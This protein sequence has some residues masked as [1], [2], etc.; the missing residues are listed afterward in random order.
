MVLRRGSD[1]GGPSRTRTSSPGRRGGRGGPNAVRGV[2]KDTSKLSRR[3]TWLNDKGG[4]ITQIRFSEVKD[5][6][7]AVGEGPAMRVLKEVEEKRSEIRDPTAW[8]RTAARRTLDNGAIGSAPREHHESMGKGK[9]RAASPM[10]AIG[11]PAGHGS[12]EAERIRKR[13]V[14]LNH[15]ASLAKELDPN[16]CTDLLVKLDR[17]DAM[18]ILKNL[19]ENAAVVRDPIAY[20][21]TSARRT[22]EGD[23]PIDHRPPAAAGRRE[24]PPPPASSSISSGGIASKGF[25]LRMGKKPGFALRTVLKSRLKSKR[26]PKNTDS[27]AVQ[28]EKRVGWLNENIDLAQELVFDEVAD[29]LIAVGHREAM[30]VLKNLEENAPQVRNPTAYVANAAHRTLEDRPLKDGGPMEDRAASARRES[31]A[32]LAV[33]GARRISEKGI[34]SRIGKRQ[35]PPWVV[36]DKGISARIGLRPVIKKGLKE[37]RD[38]MQSDKLAE[39]LETRVSWLNDNAKLAHDLVFEK[40]ADTLI[41]LGYREAMDILKDL[42]ENVDSVRDPVSYVLGA[43]R[44]AMPRETPRPPPRVTAAPVRRN[45]SPPARHL[46]DRGPSDSGEACDDELWNRISWLNQNVGLAHELKFEEVYSALVDL[47]SHHAMHILN[48]LEDNA[49]TVRDPTA[50]VIVAVRR[51]RARNPSPLSRVDDRRGSR[52]DDRRGSRPEDP[53]GS[54]PD[55][56]RGGHAEEKLRK[57]IAWLNGKAGLSQELRYQRVAP[58]LLEIGIDDAMAILKLLEENSSSVRDPNAYVSKAATRRSESVDAHMRPPAPPPVPPPAPPAPRMNQDDAFNEKLSTRISWLNDKGGLRAALSFDEVVRALSS[59]G[60]KSAM[61]ILK[62]LED[63]ADNIR[64]PNGF[65]IA[66][67]RRTDV[68]SDGGRGGGSAGSRS[69]GKLRKRI[70]WLNRN[71][72]LKEP[73][74]LDRMDRELQ[75]VDPEEAM[76]ILR[77]LEESAEK[78]RCPDKYVMSAISRAG[79]NSARRV[80]KGGG[81]KSGDGHPA[82]YVRSND[83]RSSGSYYPATSRGGGA[84]SRERSGPDPAKLHKRIDWLNSHM[85]FAFPLEIDT[86]TPA[87]AEVKLKEAMSIL[88]R[89]EEDASSDLDPNGYVLDAVDGLLADDIPPSE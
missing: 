43:A 30:A 33:T 9:G 73:L 54:W 36:N 88:K 28:I 78:V 37:K 40:V 10:M 5:L 27:L 56:R 3:I 45:V 68:H 65:V 80:G 31:H 41:S 66:Q 63:S 14:W 69:D 46:V 32:P 23:R 53:R 7:S 76:E 11:G 62:S 86:V 50:Y 17:R 4:L 83:A 25:S 55:D 84:D 89:L 77:R 39:Q 57:R 6:L 79:G 29:S 61:E 60:I 52:L 38:S 15:N 16:Q 21:S 2:V 51:A 20:V 44:R 74:T 48:E 85:A 18:D 70:E 19:E 13:V 87:L 22:R 72:P 35:A 1:G 71:V 34:S 24:Q 42:E 12:E 67:A 81:S 49:A 8:L 58:L 64:D 59:V 82:S 75:T 26:E 47:E